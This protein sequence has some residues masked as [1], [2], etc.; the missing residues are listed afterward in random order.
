MRADL[1]TEIIVRLLRSSAA[2]LET[3]DI[4]DRARAEKRKLTR[5]IVFKRLTTLRGDGVISGKQVGSGKGVWIWWDPSAIPPPTPKQGDDKLDTTILTLL[6]TEAV[7]ETTEI[8]ELVRKTQ[9]RAT[10]TII[11]RRLHNLRGD[12]KIK[13]SHI[14]SGKGVWIWWRA[15]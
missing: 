15:T 7:L 2:P 9:P 11:F 3:K 14:G 8:E 12:Q 4:L 6:A 1:A 5:A 10:R 13:G